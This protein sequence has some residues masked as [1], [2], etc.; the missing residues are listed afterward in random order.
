MKQ[1]DIGDVIVLRDDRPCELVPTAPSSFAA[2]PRSVIPPTPSSATS[3][4]GN[5]LSPGDCVDDA[6]RLMQERAVR[7]IPIVEEG[8]A[9]GMISIGDLAIERDSDSALADISVAPSNT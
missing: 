4:A 8:K 7:R 1:D 2:S 6:V 9:V 3:A 5:S